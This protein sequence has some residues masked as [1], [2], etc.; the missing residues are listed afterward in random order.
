MLLFTTKFLYFCFAGKNVTR[1]PDRAAKMYQRKNANKFPVKSAKKSPNRSV[2]N[3]HV[4]S[5]KTFPVKSARTCP[6]KN[7]PK[8]LKK[9][10][11]LFTF[12]KYVNS[13][14][15]LAE[16]NDWVFNTY[17]DR[18]FACILYNAAIIL[19]QLSQ[20]PGSTY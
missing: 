16:G 17:Q 20:N 10:A 3:S 19:S 12:A 14:L 11:H 1:Y 18:F 2:V 4:K 6:N 5:V 9:L 8:Y 15:T 7:A 13:P